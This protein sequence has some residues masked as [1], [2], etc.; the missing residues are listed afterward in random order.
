[1]RI[2]GIIPSRYASTRFPGKPLAMVGGR[3]M[4]ERVYRQARRSDLLHS[5]VVATDDERIAQAVSDFGGEFVMTDSRHPSG[6]DRCAEVLKHFDG[7]YDAV[8]N[9]QGDE[10]FIQP[11]QIDL[12][13]GALLAEGVQIATLIKPLNDWMEVR[14]QQ[15]VKVVIAANGDALYFS[16]QPIPFVKDAP[17]EEWPQR[18]SMYKHIGI[19]GY[20]ADVLP[21][22]TQLSQGSLEL[23]ESLEQ[24]RWLEQGY[25]IR[26]RISHFETIAVDTPDDLVKAE[27]YF[28]SLPLSERG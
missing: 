1:M 3:T 6:T 19:Y 4:I 11:Q 9:I 16:R 15:V 27:A 13:A 18:I 20:R 21:K 26:T 2:L 22:L 12:L 24:L 23:A 7:R 14:L 28:Q 17:P 5:L 8:I 10:P 25:R